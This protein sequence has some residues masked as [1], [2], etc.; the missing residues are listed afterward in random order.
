MNTSLLQCCIDC[1]PILRKYVLGVFA[2]DELPLNLTF[3][4][5]FIANTESSSLKGSHWCVFFFPNSN[6]VEY[7]DSYGKPIDYYNDCFPKYVSNFS[8]IIINLKQLQSF[9]SSVCGMYCLFFILHRLNGVSFNNIINIFSANT[10]YN[11]EFV[12]NFISPMF[13]ECKSNVCVYNQ[14]CKSQI[15]S[16]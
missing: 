16:D 10:S 6:T 12:Y 1:T 11:D 4:C 14:V 5:A 9:N 3:P 8:T 13:S 2:A 15:K 7:F